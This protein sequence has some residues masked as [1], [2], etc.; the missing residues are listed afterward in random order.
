[1]FVVQSVNSPNTDVLFSSEM[2]PLSRPDV[3]YKRQSRSP[4]VQLILPA[5]LM[6]DEE[7]EGCCSG[8]SLVIL[9]V[10]SL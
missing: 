5:A 8:G 6:E 4:G 10:V 2:C 9:Q 3:C 1:M 7:D